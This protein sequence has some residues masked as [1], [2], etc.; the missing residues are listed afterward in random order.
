MLSTAFRYPAWLPALLLA[1]GACTP[2]GRAPQTSGLQGGAQPVVAR[3]PAPIVETPEADLTGAR[4][5]TGAEYRRLVFG[6]TLSRASQAGGR[7]VV[8]VG[9]DGRHTLRLETPTGQVGTDRGEQT[10]NADQVCWRFDRINAGRQACYTYH[11]T[12]DGGLVAVDPSGAIRPARYELRPGNP[13]R[14]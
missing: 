14:L 5:I 9:R 2:E 8:H 12:V 13:E 6:N 11:L 7:L 3:A 4:Q 1:L 10:V